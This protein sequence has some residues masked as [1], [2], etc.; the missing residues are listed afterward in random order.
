V[1]NYR[2]VAIERGTPLAGV[3]HAQ[4]TDVREAGRRAL[5]K[6]G[7]R[8]EIAIMV[9]IAALHLSIL[10]VDSAPRWPTTWR[11]RERPPSCGSAR[12]SVR[13]AFRG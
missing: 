1:V 4:A 8:K 9:T 10:G 3:L 11:F 2:S 13:Y 7:A 5:I 12:W 6:S